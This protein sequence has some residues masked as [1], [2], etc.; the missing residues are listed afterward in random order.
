[1]ITIQQFELR[2]CVKIDHKHTS[3]FCMLTLTNITEC[4]LNDLR[5]SISSL[6]YFW[7]VSFFLL[8]SLNTLGSFFPALVEV[9]VSLISC[10]SD[11]PYLEYR[12]RLLCSVS[13]SCLVERFLK[14]MS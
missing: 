10:M 3:E 13:S 5:G 8:C 2:T 14:W 9:I 12:S 6:Q 11:V 4:R 1:V 7:L